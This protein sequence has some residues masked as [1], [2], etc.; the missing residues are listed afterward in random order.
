M[1]RLLKLILPLFFVAVLL[2]LFS[3]CTPTPEG[4]SVLSGKFTVVADESTYPLVKAEADTFMKLY[5]KASIT[6]ESKSTREAVAALFNQEARLAVT[7]R[8]LTA[9]EDSIAQANKIK[10]VSYKFAVEAVAFVVNPANR[11][12]EITVED[13]NKIL[14][15]EVTDWK[16]VGKGRGPILVVLRNENFGDYEFVKKEVLL[17]KDYVKDIYKVN[18]TQQVL[19][20]VVKE[21]GAIGIVPMT[22]VNGSV[23][24]L[25]LKRTGEEKFWKPDIEGIHYR[26]YPIQRFLY[27]YH[28]GEAE[29]LASGF[30]TYVTSTEGQKV[31]Y[32]NGYYPATVA[33]TTGE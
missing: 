7:T 33:T 4:E 24:P 1:K 10:P 27:F 8:E 16:R 26:S 3:S 6:V 12:S 13:L 2:A 23:K 15:G 20:T 11:D 17:D 22:W 14:S 29:K 5:T 32:K 19:E 28:R 9:E 18:T 21:K 25:A 31:A 30:I